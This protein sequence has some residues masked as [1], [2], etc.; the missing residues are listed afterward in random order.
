MHSSTHGATDAP[1]SAPAQALIAA[2]AE[3]II[4]RSALPFE[5]DEHQTVVSMLRTWL[6]DS[7]AAGIEAIAALVEHEE[8]EA[9]QAVSL[10]NGIVGDD[11]SKNAASVAV[12]NMA[13]NQLPID[14][15]TSTGTE[16][17]KIGRLQQPHDIEGQANSSEDGN[18]EWS[19]SGS[20]I[21]STKKNF[22]G[23]ICGAT[24]IQYGDHP[25][26]TSCPPGGC[27]LDGTM[28][29][30]DREESCLVELMDDMPDD[31][32]EDTPAADKNVA[33][34]AGP[35]IATNQLPIAVFDADFFGIQVWHNPKPVAGQSYWSVKIRAGAVPEIDDEDDDLPDEQPMDQYN[36]HFRSSPRNFRKAVKVHFEAGKI[37]SAFRTHLDATSNSFDTGVHVALLSQPVNKKFIK[38]SS[39]FRVDSNDSHAGSL[40]SSFPASR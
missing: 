11:S 37:D 14:Q 35:S 7:T 12:F 32:N 31:L 4:T 18:S 29:C 20:D 33:L 6:A 21:D 2:T 8:F 25:A 38:G 19:L 36:L 39:L 40:K 30:I 5:H 26:T 23:V 27:H 28:L 24:L 15:F 16:S 22:E 3:T 9:T 13:T 34:V 10:I 1:Q 17:S